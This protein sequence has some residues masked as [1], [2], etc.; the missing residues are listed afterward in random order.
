MQKFIINDNAHSYCRAEGSFILSSINDE[1][2]YIM[3]YTG[4]YIVKNDDGSFSREFQEIFEQEYEVILLDRSIN[5]KVNN[6]D[7]TKKSL[8]KLKIAAEEWEKVN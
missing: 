1:K 2:D 6:L 5:R 3:I 8:E 7:E 4:D